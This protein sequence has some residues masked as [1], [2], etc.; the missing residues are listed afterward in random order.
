M[1]LPFPV[2]LL[3][4]GV[5]GAVFIST[6]LDVP[7]RDSRQPLLLIITVAM[8]AVAFGTAFVGKLGWGKPELE[9][10]GDTLFWRHTHQ[11]MLPVRGYAVVLLLFGIINLM[12]PVR[13]RIGGVILLV[14]GPILLLIFRAL[15][16][17]TRVSPTT[18]EFEARA[19]GSSERHVIDRATITEQ[20][21]EDDT[22]VVP[23]T[24]R[25]VMRFP[26]NEKY[27]DG[28]YTV[29]IP[30]F[31]NASVE[32]VVQRLGVPLRS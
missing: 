19:L 4:I 20:W 3:I 8:V 22:S 23:E 16:F 30:R 9:I 13:S 32:E 17:S 25:W 5:L 26:P 31:S 1:R 6:A 29:D 10:I 15:N 12:N 27:P 14:A 21:V 18:V 24:Y 7:M 11:Q 2:T 28:T